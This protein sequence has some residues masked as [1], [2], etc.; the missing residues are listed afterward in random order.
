[1]KKYHIHLLGIV[2]LLAA[3]AAGS[4]IRAATVNYPANQPLPV[5]EATGHYVVVISQSTARQP[6]WM[7]VANIL[8]KKYQADLVI[9]PDNCVTDAL[10]PLKRLQPRYIAFVAAP[11]EAGRAYVVAIHRMVRKIAPDPWTDAQWGIVTGY[12]ASDA[13]RIASLTK[14]L[15]IQ[16]AY[17]STGP[18]LLTNM[19][20][21]FATA[22]GN[23]QKFWDKQKDQKTQLHKVSP[24]A[25]HDLA[26]SFASIKPQLVETSGHASQ[27]NWLLGYNIPGGG[28]FARKGQLYV[29]N[30]QRHV[31]PLKSEDPK[32]FLPAGSCLIGDIPGPDCM[33]TAWIHSGG[34]D[35]SFGY[36]VVTF[37]G[38]VGWGVNHYF[39]SAQTTLSQAFQFS[40]QALLYK[41]NTQ[42]PQY[43]NYMIPV[44]G[45]AFRRV[46]RTLA[47]VG[48]HDKDCLGLLWDRDTVAFYGDPA[49]QA[50]IKPRPRAWK[51]VLTSTPGSDGVEHD[52]FTLTTTKAGKWAN[53]P[54][55]VPL[56]FSLS[57]VA[58][59]KAS[60]DLKPVV[61]DDFIL[62]PLKGPF[63]ADTRVT[64]TFDA[65]RVQL[66]QTSADNPAIRIS[67]APADR[68]QAKR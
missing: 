2:A 31:W 50:R 26:R 64:V 24:D 29:F 35:Q 48:S 68:R 58:H 62:L 23:A 45:Y 46:N 37:Y 12:E 11:T 59:V 15:V 8:R 6:K 60:G 40:N 32:V 56:P 3:V 9:V 47:A 21:G 34:V 54:V 52:S 16:S 61:A 55:I 10:K 36:T 17:S 57:H 14:P 42:F 41:L 33:T 1:M 5:P 30:T 63:A 44:D 22:G 25:A 49:W 66:P 19:Q 28:L 27:H 13:K 18:G 65:A 7:K 43:A 20:T 67:K 53:R 4:D 39:N 38:Y 51:A